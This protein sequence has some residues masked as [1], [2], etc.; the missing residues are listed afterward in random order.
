[1]LNKITEQEM[2]LFLKEVYPF[3]DKRALQVLS[4]EKKSTID[5]SLE[6]VIAKYCTESKL[7]DFEYGEFSLSLIMGIRKCK[8]PAAVLLM[9]FYIKDRAKGKAAILQR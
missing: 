8:F 1:M 2:F 7:T 6:D 4:K 5:N 9:D 3:A